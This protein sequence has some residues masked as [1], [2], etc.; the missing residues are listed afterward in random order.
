[1]SIAQDGEREKRRVEGKSEERGVK[2]IGASA[3]QILMPAGRTV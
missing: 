3:A 1:M 2:R